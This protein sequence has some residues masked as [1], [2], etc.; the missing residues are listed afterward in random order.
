MPAVPAAEVEDRRVLSH[1]QPPN[2]AVNERD[3]LALVTM[4][5][6][7]LVVDRVEPWHEPIRF[8]RALGN[9]RSGVHV[10]L[11]LETPT[12]VR[13]A[14]VAGADSR[15][16]DLD[17]EVFRKGTGCPECVRTPAPAVH[18]KG[19]S[20]WVG[21]SPTSSRRMVPLSGSRAAIEARSWHT[22]RLVG[23]TLPP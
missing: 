15:P 22:I 2:Q 1:R 6:E 17:Q 16:I 9:R 8:D 23:A 4:R 3:G 21:D 19:P 10:V 20:E 7:T 5:I 18:Q 13:G 12:G 11:L 14:T